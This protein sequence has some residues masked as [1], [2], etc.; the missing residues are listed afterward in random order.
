ME[1]RFK[2]ST[3]KEKG[4]IHEKAYNLYKLNKCS[5][6]IHSL[7]YVMGIKIGYL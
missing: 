6:Y 2:E 5:T 7:L 3:L 4:I 1:C